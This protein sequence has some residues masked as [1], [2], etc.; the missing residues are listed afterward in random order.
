M[1]NILYMNEQVLPALNRHQRQDIFSISTVFS[2]EACLQLV[3]VELLK[4]IPD[5]NNT[6]YMESQR[7][8]KVQNAIFAQLFALTKTTGKKLSYASI[9]HAFGGELNSN[10]LR[11]ITG[12]LNEVHLATWKIAV[13]K[14]YELLVSKTPEGLFRWNSEI[15]PIIQEISNMIG[16]QTEWLMA[17]LQLKLST[18]VSK[19]KK[20]SVPMSQYG[21]EYTLLTKE[22]ICKGLD[23]LFLTVN[24]R[25]STF[26][27]LYTMLR[28]QFD[29]R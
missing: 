20:G 16:V 17:N 24:G 8:V 9:I 10:Y 23:E 4:A 19:S 3:E 13:A 21:F 11:K 7:L 12:K 1:C 5:G 28:K 14:T 25:N 29:E 15:L 18:M 26:L 27:K 22:M 6:L 2:F